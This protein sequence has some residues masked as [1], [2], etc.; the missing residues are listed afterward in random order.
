MALFVGARPFRSGGCGEPVGVGEGGAFGV[1]G[2]TLTYAHWFNHNI[3]SQDTGAVHRIQPRAASNAIQDRLGVRL[4]KVWL[5]QGRLLSGRV[6]VE[7]WKRSAKTD[8][9]EWLDPSKSR[10]KRP[11]P[12]ALR[13]ATSGSPF[14]A[15]AVTDWSPDTPT[16]GRGPLFGSPGTSAHRRRMSETSMRD[17]AFGIAR[18]GPPRR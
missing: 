18:T 12:A 7:E 17:R 15:H 5:H 14:V 2:A 13:T 3:A 4:P 6:K 8:G 1:V 11:S 10:A 16:S 9:I